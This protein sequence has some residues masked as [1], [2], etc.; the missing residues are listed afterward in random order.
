MK[1]KS[2]VLLLLFSFISYAKQTSEVMLMGTFHFNNPGLDTVKS[3]QINVMTNENQKYL[4]KLSK[5]I[6]KFKPQLILLEFNPKNTS[7]INMEYQDYL[8]GHFELPANEIYQIGFRVAKYA[9]VERIESLDEREIQWEAEKLFQHLESKDKVAGTK[10]QKLIDELTE[11]ISIRHSQLT[12]KKLLQLSNDDHEDN[13]NKNLYMLTNSMGVKEG[14]FVGAD[15]TASWWHR[16]FRIYAKI[17]YHAQSHTKIF[18]LAGQGHTAIL[19]DFLKADQEIT[20]VKPR[21]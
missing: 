1:H 12:L 9:G 16:N 10:F 5:K 11:K 21:F 19:K 4:D 15:S 7:L 18:A 6:S 8:K 20:E 2:L 13:L 17:Q 3:K 14:T